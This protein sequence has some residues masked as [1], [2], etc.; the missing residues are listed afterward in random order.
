[1]VFS[2]KRRVCD[3]LML[4]TH[5]A[6]YVTFCIGHVDSGTVCRFKFNSVF[7]NWAFRTVLQQTCSFLLR[8]YKAS[9][10]KNDK[11][12]CVF[13]RSS[14]RA[15]VTSRARP[16]PCAL[17]DLPPVQPCGS[18]R[19]AAWSGDSAVACN[20]L[21][22]R[23]LLI[24]D[25]Y[26]SS[27]WIQAKIVTNSRSARVHSRSYIEVLKKLKSLRCGVFCTF[28]QILPKFTKG[29]YTFGSFALKGL[30][31]CLGNRASWAIIPNRRVAAALRHS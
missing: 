23:Q 25:N 14:A 2:L 8:C 22:P 24:S 7:K 9:K 6:V 18:M 3:D 12:S 5:S 26:L 28:Y 15:S 19:P 10:A 29:F 13:L 17:P 20:E 4:T 31:L 27:R 16:A 1:M 21:L 30:Q 11:E